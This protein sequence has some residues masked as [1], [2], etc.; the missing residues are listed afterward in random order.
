MFVSSNNLP[1]RLLCADYARYYTT[2]DLF[3]S[4]SV[5]LSILD[6]IRRKEGFDFFI[7][8]EDGQIKLDETMFTSGEMDNN[9]SF[10]DKNTQVVGT[11]HARKY[12]RPKYASI[13]IFLKLFCVYF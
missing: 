5:L 3:L 11:S 7:D 8:V 12:V 1:P 2:L 10:Q 9:S 6:I 4:E 13:F